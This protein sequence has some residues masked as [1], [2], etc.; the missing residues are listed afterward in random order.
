MHVTE[1]IQF[2]QLLVFAGVCLASSTPQAGWRGG[3]PLQ[4]GT[5]VLRHLVCH[6]MGTTIVCF[7]E[8]C[9]FVFSQTLEI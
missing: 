9:G 7:R 2:G 3:A 1:L 8:P 4:E 5:S 6:A